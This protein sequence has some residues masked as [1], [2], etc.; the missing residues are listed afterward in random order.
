MLPHRK[1]Q[2]EGLRLHQISTALNQDGNALAP[3]TITE[4]MLYVLKTAAPPP[5]HCLIIWVVYGWNLWFADDCYDCSNN[6][7]W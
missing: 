4:M 2:Q 1:R 5:K 7:G 6:Y 3:S